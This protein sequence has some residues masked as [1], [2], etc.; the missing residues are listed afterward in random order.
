MTRPNRL[1]ITGLL[2]IPAVTL[3]LSGVLLLVVRGSL[4]TYEGRLVLS[5][6]TASVLVE[7]DTLGVPSVSAAHRL[8]ATRALGFL[9]AQER[10]F[11]MDLIRRSAA[12][13]LAELVPAAL[14][15]D[16]AVRPYR[17][18]AHAQATLEGLDPYQ[19]LLIEA[20]SE[21][22]NAGLD[23]LSVRPFEYL[24]LRSKP[25]PWRPADSLLVAQAMAIDMQDERVRTD[26]TRGLLKEVLPP[27]LYRFLYRN[28]SG[29]EATLD[30]S[31]RPVVP[32]PGPEVFADHDF[33]AAEDRL[34]SG[35]PL[36]PEET[37]AA[38]NSLAVAGGLNEDGPGGLL[39]NDM[40]LGLNV[41]NTWYRATLHYT[42]RGG[43][44]VTVHGA[45]LPGTPVFAVGSNGRLAWGVTNARADVEDAV[46]IIPDPEQPDAAYL[47]PDGPEDF[48]IHEEVIEVKGGEPEILM[49]RESGWGPIIT[50]DA[51]GLPVAVLWAALQPGA[52]DFRMIELELADSVEAGIDVVTAANNLILHYLFAD[53]DGSIAFSPGGWLP[54]RVGFD[55]RYPQRSDE[56][57]WGWAGRR[58]PADYPRIVDPPSGRLWTAN[59]RVLGGDDLSVTGD[60]GYVHGIRAWQIR[61]RLESADSFDHQAFLDIMLDHEGLALQP[62]QTL[63]LE[64]L[65]PA[66][67][68]DADLAAYRAV[69]ADWN[70]YAAKESVAYRLI[71]VFRS[72]M[73]DRVM[74]R[75]VAPALAADPDFVAFRVP[76]EGPVRQ[77]L[78]T[79][80][81]HLV[82]PDHGS[83]PAEIRA[84][85]AAQLADLRERG[86]S[87][88]NYTWGDRVT[89]A[90]RHP[91]SRGLPALS[92]VLDMEPEPMDGDQLTPL[93]MKADHGP[94]QRMVVSPGR[95][96]RGIFHM[97]G[98][99]SGHPV[100]PHYRR[101]HQLWVQGIP[102]PL[103]P[104][105]PQTRLVL[106]PE[107]RED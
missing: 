99:Q 58:D 82:D 11:Q 88:D 60:G 63:L 24:L 16:R 94:S 81:G 104:D 95:D 79:Q 102:A 65:G 29:Y 22:V 89:L 56:S 59:N 77:V 20:Y 48:V 41:P 19:R 44:G 72:A 3:L 15:V 54:E 106:N 21:G 43:R 7:R 27:E 6:L 35:E 14:R 86:Y 73:I 38:S 30:G 13:E 69:V 75:L 10:F 1:L 83:W 66:E 18:R 37:V 23:E 17:L 93:A 25:E 92:G 53:E 68:L 47:T 32:V 28:G 49:V 51:A 52:L 62:W 91:I 80:P 90:M 2:F 100:S 78:E 57:G 31:D 46:V 33:L 105:E 98:G 64:G 39:A 85:V 84:V 34:A 101:G 42:A 103:E 55:G 4:P 5:G 9:H 87:L 74:A 97:P 107:P 45:T 70:G 26:R 40:H 8:D 50:E 71:R 96:Y 67:D 61:Q 76:A 36:V 12:G